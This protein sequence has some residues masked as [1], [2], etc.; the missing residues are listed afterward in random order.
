MELQ[1]GCLSRGHAGTYIPST[2]GGS[3]VDSNTGVIDQAKLSEN[4]SLAYISR[5]D[6][7]PCGDS[8]I[9]LYRGADSGEEQE[10]WKLLIFLKGP[11]ANKKALSTQDPTLYTNFKLVW[12]VRTNNVVHDLPLYVFFLP[13]FKPDCP[14]PRC[15]LGPPHSPLLWYPEGPPLSHLPFPIADPQ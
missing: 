10:E 7:S 13:C 11:K 15:H 2:L 8:I 4:M 12:Q 5:V 6:K 9:N 3:C 1:N 14:H